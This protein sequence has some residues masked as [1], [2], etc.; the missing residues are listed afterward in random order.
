M[1]E[2]KCLF[3]RSLVFLR[4]NFPSMHLCSV[5]SSEPLGRLENLRETSGACVPGLLCSS[6]VGKSPAWGRRA[7]VLPRRPSLFTLLRLGQVDKSAEL[8]GSV[9][10]PVCPS[11]SYSPQVSHFQEETWYFVLHLPLFSSS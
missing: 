11:L 8:W 9:S 6:L 10:K 1:V 5:P 3:P 2:G 4:K 7:R